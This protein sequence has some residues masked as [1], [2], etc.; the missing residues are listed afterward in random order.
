MKIFFNAS[1]TGKKLYKSNYLAIIDQLEKLD[2]TII[3]AP[4][5]TGDITKVAQAS[6]Q[7]AEKYY[8]DLMKSIAAADINVFEVSYPSTGIGHEIAVSLHRGKPVIALYVKGKNP[9][10]F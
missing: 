6:Q 10:I 9:Y 1:L 2:H 4:V 5:K 7:Q 8:E 3:S